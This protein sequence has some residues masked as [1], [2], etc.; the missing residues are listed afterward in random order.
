MTGPAFDS[1]EDTPRAVCP[2]CGYTLDP[3]AS[4]GRCSECG[5]SPA[6]ILVETD[7]RVTFCTSAPQ[8]MN[9]VFGLCVI[10]TVLAFHFGYI[11]SNTAF[12]L[13]VAATLAL[14]AGALVW[15][16]RDFSSPHVMHRFWMMPDEIIIHLPNGCII[17]LPWRTL[18]SAVSSQRDP[19][20][21]SLSHRLQQLSPARLD[22]SPPDAHYCTLRF[23]STVWPTLL[24]P[25]KMIVVIIPPERREV[26]NAKLREVLR[27]DA[28]PAAPASPP[29]PLQSPDVRDD[30]QPARA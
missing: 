21:G 14:L 9:V 30:H 23:Y 18:R 7:A 26:F 17:R 4:S 28:A 15:H 3:L 20:S 11:S 13:T 12:V 24:C 16:V 6:D 22:L 10:A 2:A 27:P 29:D 8:M 1:G 25:V 19:Q 5:L